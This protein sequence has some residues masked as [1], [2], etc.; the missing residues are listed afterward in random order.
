VEVRKAV[1]RVVKKA[2]RDY[3]VLLLSFR[4]TTC[5]MKLKGDCAY[6]ILSTVSLTNFYR[7]QHPVIYSLAACMRQQQVITGDPFAKHKL[8]SYT[9]TRH[10]V[11]IVELVD[12]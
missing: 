8:R 5:P 9:K 11:I 2:P 12:E 1:R 7:K 6:N 3:P 4:C 10:D